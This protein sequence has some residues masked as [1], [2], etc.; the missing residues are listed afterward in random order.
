MSHSL[1][2]I[3]F[4]CALVESI[5]YSTL[6]VS[7]STF[8]TVFVVVDV[9]SAVRGMSSAVWSVSPAVWGVSTVVTPTSA[10]ISTAPAPSDGGTG[11]ST[12]SRVIL[13]FVP[14]VGAPCVIRVHNLSVQR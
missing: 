2:R 3:A 11:P 4:G 7:S 8:M 6:W 14:S 5:T 13:S 10:V 12:F 1:T 9:I